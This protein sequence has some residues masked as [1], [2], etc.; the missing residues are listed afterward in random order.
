M[1]Q[2]EQERPPPGH[3][4]IPR[5]LGQDDSSWRCEVAIPTFKTGTDWNAAQQISPPIPGPFQSGTLHCRSDSLWPLA[6]ERT[7]HRQ[8]LRGTCTACPSS[9]TQVIRHT[10][11]CPGC[12][13]GLLSTTNTS[14]PNPQLGVQSSDQGAQSRAS[15]LSP[16]R[17][18]QIT[19]DPQECAP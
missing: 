3:H 8:R 16:G 4:Y 9:F 17:P 12:H 1:G 14:E 7:R 15:S 6:C 13:V 5:F 18:D 2:S 19:G 11:P 10:R